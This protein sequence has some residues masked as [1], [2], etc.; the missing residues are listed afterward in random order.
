MGWRRNRAAGN[1]S[2]MKRGSEWKRQGLV[3][4]TPV[5]VTPLKHGGRLRRRAAA[6]VAAGDG[7]GCDAAAATAGVPCD[8]GCCDG[9]RLPTGPAAT[10]A[11][12]METE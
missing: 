1:G 4:R 12:G 8:G 2:G 7:S 5:C 6:T 11:E 10:V 3:P 9:G